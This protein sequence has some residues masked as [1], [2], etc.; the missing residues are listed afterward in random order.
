[1]LFWAW[2]PKKKKNMWSCHLQMPSLHSWLTTFRDN[3]KPVW[4]EVEVSE[5]L[6]CW[7]LSPRYL[8][9]VNRPKLVR[10]R[11][12]VLQKYKL[13]YTSYLL[14]HAAIAKSSVKTLFCKG[15]HT[16]Q[17]MQI[18]GSAYRMIRFLLFFELLIL[19]YRDN[20]I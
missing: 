16:S 8:G 9:S 6:N 15:G 1:M 20:R 3:C 18:S 4:Q 7:K 19:L 5:R 10:E 11:L 12:S 13:P 17:R 14:S 2:F